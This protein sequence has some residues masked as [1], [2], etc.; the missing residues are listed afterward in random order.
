MNISNPGTTQRLFLDKRARGA[1][2]G[3]PLGALKGRTAQANEFARWLRKITAGV[4]VRA[5]EEDFP[6]AKSSWSGFRD[7]SRLP[8]AD[9]IEQAVARYLPEPIMRK[10]QLEHGLNLLAAAQEAAKDLQGQA[11][12]PRADL[13]MTL[14]AHRRVDPTTAALL[15]LD[16]AR[17]RQIDAMQKLAASERR[18][19]EL[20]AMVS[21]LEQ[22]ITILESERE[23]AREESRAELQRELQMSL[24]YRRQ[25]DEKLRHARRAEERAH[26]LRLAAEK[27]VARERVAVLHVDR[28]KAADT[29]L[30]PPP[31]GS[32]A[33]ELQ[34]PPL[35]H[36][37]ELLEVAQE[38]LEVQDGELDELGAQLDT[39]AARPSRDESDATHIV[40]GHVVDATADTGDVPAHTLNNQGKPLTSLDGA[41]AAA[42]IEPAPHVAAL[43]KSVVAGPISPSHELVGDLGTVRTPDALSKVLSRL[44][45]RTGVGSIGQLTDRMPVTMRDEVFRASVGRWVDGDDLPDSWPH[46]Q[47]L[48]GLMGATDDEIVAFRQAYD[49]IIDDRSTGWAGA[50]GDLAD[51]TPLTRGL[52]RILRGHRTARART[53]EWIITGATPL[54]VAAVTTAYSSA[55]RAPHPVSLTMLIGYGTVLL[56]VCLFLLFVTARVAALCAGPGRPRPQKRFSA[57]A[58]AVGALA[59]PGGLTLPWLVESD[60]PGRWFAHLIGLV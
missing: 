28:D 7:G 39:P 37:R 24:E 20:E 3:R 43:A 16:D 8:P 60:V 23:Q 17:L 11:S 14:A 58:L 6:Y 5:L 13:S 54:I 44:L 36:F 12:D 29:V 26:Q 32:A 9:L 49:R 42:Q 1:G 57:A 19:E 53:G 48:V 10:R 46:L 50:K 27:Q 41:G 56:A 59:V 52:H 40:W 34:L 2:M 47:T 22:R 18:R 51:L 4:T 35:H 31:P 38:Q 45:R 25:A 33:D 30:P 15:R 21:V 55:L